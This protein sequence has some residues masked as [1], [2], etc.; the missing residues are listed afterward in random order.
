MFE[1]ALKVVSVELQEELLW[2]SQRDFLENLWSEIKY[3][4]RKSGEVQWKLAQFIE[5]VYQEADSRR[6]DIKKFRNEKG[7]PITNMFK[8]IIREVAKDSNIALSND[9]LSRLINYIRNQYSSEG[10][11]R[12]GLYPVEAFFNRS[13][14]GIPEDLGDDRSCFRVGGCNYGSSLWLKLEDEK[15][16][17]AK[18][19]IFS[20]E[21]K[22]KTGVGRC[23]LYTVS[24]YAIFATNFYSY[25][26]EI[27]SH[28]LKYS[29]VRVLRLLAGLSEDVKF[30]YG[31]DIDLPIYLN[32]DGLIVYEKSQ[33]NNSDEVIELSRKIVSECMYCRE[34][35]NLEDLYRF[36]GD[37]YYDGEEV[38]G[39]I[40]CKWCRDQLENLEVCVGCGER[41][42]RD[43]MY[44]QDDRWW[45]EDC[46]NERFEQCYT[47]DEYY[48]REDMIVDRD[49]HWLCPDCADEYRRLCG[50][51]GEYVYPD[52]VHMYEV[53]TVWGIEEAYVCNECEEDL[54]EMKCEHCSREFFY[55]VEDY[56]RDERIREIVRA[57]LCYECFKERRRALRREIFDNEK[58][59]SLPFDAI[60]VVLI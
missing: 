40:V 27:R 37:E 20:Y 13:E 2:E 10:V 38:S 25:R 30:V 21:A 22:D 24:P 33:F 47:C 28:W 11:L 4:L 58:Q 7:E 8:R 5:R 54:R 17:R 34:D 26:F 46:F 52:E 43:V 36:D 15:Y 1:K 31:R 16:N 48:W 35:V 18:L 41:L 59:P 49:G 12:A 29:I 44:Y 32:G 6:V 55:S 42:D 50:V 23:W 14:Y 19:V 53:L 51:C 57:G 9:A 60:D 45:C 3:E 56:R 39:L